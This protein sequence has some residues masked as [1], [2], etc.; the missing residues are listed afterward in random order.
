M[1][2]DVDPN[3]QPEPLDPEAIIKETQ[4]DLTLA[5]RLKGIKHRNKRVLVFTDLDA[6]D[7][8]NRVNSQLQSLVDAAGNVDLSSE[9][10]PD[11][12]QALLDKHNALEPD[13]DKA[14]E[15]MMESALAIQLH[16]YPNIAIKVIRRD[17]RKKFIDPALKEIP[18]DRIAEYREYIDMRML[19]EA[20]QSITDSNGAQLDLG[21]KQEVGALLSDQLPPSQWQRLY[22][23]FIQVTLTDQISTAAQND[24]GF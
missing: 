17:A 6:V 11:R 7:R 18:E 10:G 8:Y 1:T 15:E 14:R 12:H 16:A 22:D 5:G 9:G 24:P 2:D 21:P 23:E 3:A 20:I 19:S 4:A 13:L